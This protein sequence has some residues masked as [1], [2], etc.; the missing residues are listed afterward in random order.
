MSLVR[1]AIAAERHLAELVDSQMS[2]RD[3]SEDVRDAYRWWRECALRDRAL[4]FELYRAALDHEQHAASVH[5][6]S[7][8][9]VRAVRS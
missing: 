7:A 9:R 3:A 5:E 1:N 6:D 8:Q 4:A 2:W